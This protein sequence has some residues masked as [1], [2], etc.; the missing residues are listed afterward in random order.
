M[1]LDDFQSASS[2]DEASSGAAVSYTVDNFYEGFMDDND[3]PSIGGSDPMSGM[4]QGCCEADENDGAI[5]SSR[6]MR[7][8][9]GGSRA[10]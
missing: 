7:A 4:T 3:A 1:V 10:S 6:R 9:S 2:E 8:W 5:F